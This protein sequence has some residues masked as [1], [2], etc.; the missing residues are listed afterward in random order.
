MRTF[1][2]SS[3]PKGMKGRKITKD[4]KEAYRVRLNSRQARQLK[5]A[6]KAGKER[7]EMTEI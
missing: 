1:H 3:L 5:R 7:T 4:G 2:I 6:I